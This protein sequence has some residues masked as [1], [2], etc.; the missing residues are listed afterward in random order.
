MSTDTELK[1]EGIFV[2]KKLNSL[3]IHS[4]AKFVSNKICN[5]FPEQNLNE[6]ILFI[7]LSKLNMCIAKLP[8]DRCCCKILLQKFYAIF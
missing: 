1:K 3:Q 6:D 5:T 7:E 4:I 8:S 2:V